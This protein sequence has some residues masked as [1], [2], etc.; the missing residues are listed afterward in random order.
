MFIWVVVIVVGIWC[1]LICWMLVVGQLVLVVVGF[2]RV[3]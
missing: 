1:K 2:S 3:A